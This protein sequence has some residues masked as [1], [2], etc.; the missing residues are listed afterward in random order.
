MMYLKTVMRER[1]KTWVKNRMRKL[2]SSLFQF[3]V[4]WAVLCSAKL[5]TV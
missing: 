5:I 4:T 3:K 2:Q 1:M